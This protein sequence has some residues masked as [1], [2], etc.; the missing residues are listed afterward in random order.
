MICKPSEVVSLTLILIFK[1]S[2]PKHQTASQVGFWELFSWGGP[3]VSR[4]SSGTLA[5]HPSSREDFEQGGTQ[6]RLAGGLKRACDQGPN[7]MV[8]GFRT[9]S[10]WKLAKTHQSAVALCLIITTLRRHRIRKH[11]YILTVR[12][13]SW[14]PARRNLSCNSIAYDELELLYPNDFGDMWSHVRAHTKCNHDHLPP[15]CYPVGFSS[16]ASQYLPLWLQ[17]QCLYIGIC[18]F[19]LEIEQTTLKQAFITDIWYMAPLI[20]RQAYQ[21]STVF[22]WKF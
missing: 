4:H 22:H 9:I 8:S 14:K 2:P 5:R 12:V 20:S 6:R 7:L 18:T 13:I 16:S 21:V 1:M 17:N 11:S 3:S 15:W 10:Y 19:M